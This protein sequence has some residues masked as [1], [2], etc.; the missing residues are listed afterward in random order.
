MKKMLVMLVVAL[1]LGTVALADPADDFGFFFAG[2]GYTGQWAEVDALGL[3]FCLP[4]GWVALEPS[5]GAYFTAVSGDGTV[6]LDIRVEADGIDDLES[7]ATEHLSNF[8]MDAAGL[9]EALVVEPNENGIGVA[10][11]LSDGRLAHFRFAR[12]GEEDMPREYALEI[13]GTTSE[14][15]F[16]G[17]AEDADADELIFGDLDAAFEGWDG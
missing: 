2:E 4:D 12:A 14:N 10:I 16:S 13:V 7:W 8:A 5:D 15:A 6:T 9:Y 17:D 11:K 1:L 3:E